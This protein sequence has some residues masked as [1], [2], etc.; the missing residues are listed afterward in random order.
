MMSATQLSDICFW[1]AKSDEWLSSF[2][3]QQ[4][5]L[6]TSTDHDTISVLV[7]D[8]KRETENLNNF[9]KHTASVRYLLSS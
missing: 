3:A 9:L 6:N 2:R 1:K 8:I 4:H 5:N 7:N